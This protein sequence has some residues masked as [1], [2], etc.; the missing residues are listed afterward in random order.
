MKNIEKYP[1]TKAALDAY[2]SLDFKRVPFDTWLECEYEE[3]HEKTLLEAA[4]AVIDEWY[5]TQDNVTLNDLGDKMV[6]LKK[7]IDR[8]K[9]K[10]VRNC[11]K[12]KTVKE[13]SIA[14]TKMCEGTECEKCCYNNS[15]RRAYG[16][17][18]AWLYAEA[19]KEEARN[20]EG[21]P[22]E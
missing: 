15:T 19:E 3:P 10:P 12:Y 17:R 20:E 8:E 6:D 11:D 7:A 18:F 1:N 22:K 21:N 16:C 9:S 13:A 5:Y 4:E 2:N 14:F